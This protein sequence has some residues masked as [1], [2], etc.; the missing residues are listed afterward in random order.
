V[1]IIDYKDA[2]RYGDILALKMSASACHIYTDLDAKRVASIN[3][4]IHQPKILFSPRKFYLIK[5]KEED[6]TDFLTL[7]Q[8]RKN[9]ELYRKTDLEYL[10]SCCAIFHIQ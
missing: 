9:K 5:L 8:F 7:R 10:C 4:N 3:N 1:L 6:P 2:L